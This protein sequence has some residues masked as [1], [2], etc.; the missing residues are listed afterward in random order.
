MKRFLTLAAITAI[1]FPAIAQDR[2]QDGAQNAA[3]SAAQDAAPQDQDEQDWNLLRDPAKKSVIAYIP[4]TT[5]LM[6]AVRCVDGALDGVI[7]GL[8]QYRAGRPTRP[9]GLAFGDEP[10]RQTRWSVTT[11]RTVAI[12]DYPAAFARSLRK[13]GPLK[14]LIPGGAEDGRN[15]RHDLVLP[16]S[17]AAIE[18]TLAACNRPL[19]DPR[20]ALLPDIEDNGLPAGLTWARPPRARYPNTNLASGYVVITC[21]AQSDG[22][23]SQCQIES[24]QP[25]KSRFGAAALQ[26]TRD[27]R[28][29]VSDQ[30]GGQIT[31][32]MIAFRANFYMEGYQPRRGED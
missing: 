27:A 18:E 1:A 7:T 32:R 29:N 20:D 9:L 12:S 13:G 24:E 14:I 15:L 17:A 23:L 30:P 11:D 3:P 25:P 22:S 16:P 5:G 2:A 8:P 31:P 19:E 21:I 4:V 10:M 28:L 6:L 26:S